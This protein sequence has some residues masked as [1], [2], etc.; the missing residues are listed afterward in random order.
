MV[1]SNILEPTVIVKE[2]LAHAGTLIPVTIR[3]SST[4][5]W[6]FDL[7]HDTAAESGYTDFQVIDH[8]NYIEFALPKGTA[9]FAEMIIHDEDGKLIWKTQ[10]FNSRVI[11]WDKQTSIGEKAPKGLYC[12][13]VRQGGHHVD[14]VTMVA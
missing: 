12:F 10:S 5:H 1:A 2:T 4:R 11:R 3:E 13:Q 6:C 7:I 9:Q 14:G 8:G